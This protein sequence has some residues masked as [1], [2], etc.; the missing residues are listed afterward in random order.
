MTRFIPFGVWGTRALCGAYCLHIIGLILQLVFAEWDG[1]KWKIET[2]L[3]LAFYIMMI[4]I[5][6]AHIDIISMILNR[7]IEHI[8]ENAVFIKKIGIGTFIELVLWGIGKL[9]N[10]FKHNEGKA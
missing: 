4:F 7:T 5:D 10:Y 6:I 2:S 9:A 1:L 8:E 3:W